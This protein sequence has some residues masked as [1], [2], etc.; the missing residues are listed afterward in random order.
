M[1]RRAAHRDAW[2]SVTPEPEAELP[3]AVAA[4][5]SGGTPAADQIAAERARIQAVVMGGRE[6]DWL[7]YL[8]EVVGLVQHGAA[9]AVAPAREVAAEVVLNHHQLLLGL[10]GDAGD[11]TAAEREQLQETA[12]HPER[13]GKR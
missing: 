12:T 6:R 10:P 9:G 8:S 2:L 4:L 1:S 13:N 5:R 7:A 3:A 11:R